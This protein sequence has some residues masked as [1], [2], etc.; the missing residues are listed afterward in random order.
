MHR[1]RAVL[2][3]VVVTAL[4]APVGAEVVTEW[5]GRGKACR[6]QAMTARKLPDG[7]HVIRFDLPAMEGLVRVY[8]ASLRVAVKAPRTGTGLRPGRT[9]HA[10]SG[11]DAGARSP[12]GP[13]E[14]YPLAEGSTDDKPALDDRPLQL[15][16]PRYVSFDATEVVRCWMSGKR[17]NLG[18]LI[19]PCDLLDP[20]STVLEVV[21][22]G[23][24]GQLPPP[25]RDLK[26][27][28]RAG[29]TFITWTEIDKITTAEKVRYGDFRQIVA[30]PGPRGVVLYRVYRSDEPITAASIGRAE[31]IDEVGPLSGYDGRIRQNRTRGEIFQGRDPNVIVPRFCIEASPPS[32]P[33]KATGE[34]VDGRMKHPEWY[35]RQLPLHTGLYVYSP[36]KAGRSYYAVTALVNGAEN[37]R[38]I[39][40]ANSL[41]EP[42]AETAAPGEPILYRRLDKTLK[43]GRRVQVRETQFYVYW[44]GP[45]CSNLPREPI[46]ILVGVDGPLDAA[47][48]SLEVFT[49]IADMYWSELVGG[50]HPRRWR[51]RPH[52]ALQVVDDHALA[53]LGYHSAYRTLKS[54]SQGV[55]EPYTVR[56]V[57]LALAWAQK[58]W[59][60]D[61][62]RIYVSNS[63]LGLH[64]PEYFTYCVAGGHQTVLNLK[65]SPLGRALP[66]R[67]GPPEVARTA[68]G[69]SA[70]DLVDGAWLVR[71]DPAAETPFLYCPGGKGPGHQV[72]V[73]WSQ[74]PKVYRALMK[75]KRPFAAIWG[76]KDRTY[77]RFNKMAWDRNVPALGHGSLDDNP[78]SGSLYDG[79]LTGQINWFLWWDPATGV[80]EPGRW[81]LTVYLIDQAPQAECTVDVTP[82]RLKK[83]KA[84][85]GEEFRW[86]NT[87]VKDGKVVGAGTVKA[88]KWGLVTLKQVKA[89]KTRNRLEIRR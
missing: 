60:V 4:G 86:T 16:P 73:G 47:A 70:Y 89:T 49:G 31:R 18:L 40:P 87:S 82:R 22:E 2:G 85:P 59:S 52:L 42:V 25:V 24:G 88:D 1:T 65:W 81:A 15:E 84:R 43:R 41:T 28:H 78:G 26:V 67:F 56:L 21:H 23:K 19:K 51:N 8:R 29:Q 53:G 50:T 54:Y 27:F 68:D 39:S 72:E 12:A 63:F 75:T 36:R 34:F 7:S 46:H 3:I 55:V 83:F 48:R 61:P 64:L 80:D 62:G 30:K 5:W 13:I 11:V 74:N 10:A 37:T 76:R 69:R 9:L 45:P 14:I 33:F 44:V 57:K 77:D 79:D 20:Q 58:R 71:R 66:K 6:H 32:S 17:P 35:A 38:D